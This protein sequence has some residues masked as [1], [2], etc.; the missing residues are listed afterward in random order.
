AVIQEQVELVSDLP[1][2][3]SRGWCHYTPPN[4]NAEFVNR[5]SL[6]VP[7]L[8]F[9]AC[10][11]PK[12]SSNMESGFSEWSSP[13]QTSGNTDAFIQLRGFCDLKV[14]I[15]TVGMVTHLVIRP[16]SKA[17]VSAREIRSRLKGSRSDHVAVA[18]ASGGDEL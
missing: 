18:G 1:W 15:E 16:V 12:S 7:K 9:R 6:A 10:N 3:P 13:I 17:E 2:V 14:A 5:E 4:V 11:L 8:F